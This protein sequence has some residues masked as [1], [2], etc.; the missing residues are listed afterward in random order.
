MNVIKRKTLVEFWEKHNDSKS[1]LEAWYTEA[2]KSVW[3]GPADIKKRYGSADFLSNNRV[4]FNICGNKY[5]LIVKI[6]YRAKI[7][8]IRF[9]GTHAEY[10]KIDAEAV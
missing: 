6:A 8:Y 4:V 5:R 2:S 10:S 3:H 1:M 9:I 7:V